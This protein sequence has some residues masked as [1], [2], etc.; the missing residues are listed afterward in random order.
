MKQRVLLDTQVLYLSA[1]DER[2]PGKVRSLFLDS[3][4]ERLLSA[5]SLMEIAIKTAKGMLSMTNE[6][7]SAVVADL[8]LTVI[9]FTPSHAMYLFN[10]PMHHRDPFDRMLIATAIV[11]NIPLVGGDARFPLYKP[12]G[13]SVIWK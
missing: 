9:P 4:Y 12:Q 13:L 10:L 11:E 3:A 5:A 2:L 6:Q 1:V 7:T 8:R